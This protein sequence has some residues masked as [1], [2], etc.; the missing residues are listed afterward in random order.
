MASPVLVVD[1]RREGL[2]HRGKVAGHGVSFLSFC[3]YTSL[4]IFRLFSCTLIV[5]AGGLEAILLGRER[6]VAIKGYTI[7]WICWIYLRRP[8]EVGQ[9]SRFSLFFFFFCGARGRI[10]KNCNTNTNSLRIPA[11]LGIQV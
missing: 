11:V 5:F 10:L 8:R 4:F 7:I 1:V 9:F 2:E 6:D 3:Y